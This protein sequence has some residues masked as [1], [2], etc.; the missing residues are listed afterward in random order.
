[1][2]YRFL[3]EVPNTLVG[4]ANA[5]VAASGDAQV[6]LARASHG[7]GIDDEYQDLSV[8]ATNLGVV[9]QLYDW[10]HDM[11]ANRP[12]SR[13]TISL[14]LHSG[15]R[16][17]LHESDPQ[18]TIAAIRRDQPWVERSIPK[19]GEH[20]RDRFVDPVARPANMTGGT[21]LM[22]EELV[23]VAVESATQIYSVG[24][25]MS[26]GMFLGRG[27]YCL[28]R[29]MDLAGPEHFYHDVLGM[30]LIGRV[31]TADDGKLI[32]LDADYDHFT[33]AQTNTEAD[34]AFLEHGPLK[35]ALRRVGRAYPMDYGKTV[36]QFTLQVEPAL[37]HKIKA[38]VLMRG[39]T[40]LG[41]DATSFAFRDPY[42]V[43]WEI[44]PAVSA[45]AVVD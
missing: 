17:G 22:V 44:V 19:I 4:D 30:T 31:V 9:E 15:R 35:L 2:A 20:E 3:L 1:M 25:G 16:F 38:Q 33:A 28:V 21:A 39:Y 7:L 10:V 45:P 23:E 40:L 29:V 32:E 5:V 27:T 24:V 37:A 8:A 13:I 11:Q 6:L 43:A 26:E 12:E 42:A 41:E 34:L 36:N 18:Q 14:V